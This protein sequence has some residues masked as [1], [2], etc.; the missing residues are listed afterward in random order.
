M[1]SGDVPRRCGVGNAAYAR[2]PAH[3]TIRWC[4]AGSGVAA[5]PKRFDDRSKRG[6]EPADQTSSSPRPAERKR[7]RFRCAARL[8]VGGVVII[9]LCEWGAL[10]H[11]AKHPRDRP[12][13]RPTLSECLQIMPPAEPVRSSAVARAPARLR[14]L[15]LAS[16]RRSFEPSARPMH[17]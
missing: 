2:T 15:A 17:R 3:P 4:G 5:E 8:E 10:A 12:Q 9:L 13:S 1:A 11:A 7:N 16:D 6:R 14:A